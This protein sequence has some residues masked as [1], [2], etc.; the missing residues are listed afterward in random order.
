MATLAGRSGWS[1]ARFQYWENVAEDEA[2]Q[3]NVVSPSQPKDDEV[4][5]LSIVISRADCDRINGR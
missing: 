3:D 5:I 2:G 1:T 4:V